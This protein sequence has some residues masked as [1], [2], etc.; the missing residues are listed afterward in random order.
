MGSGGNPIPPLSLLD[1]IEDSAL[2]TPTWCPDELATAGPEHLDRAYVA[3]YD[4][5]ASTD[6][7]AE[8]AQLRD[9]GQKETHT[10]VDL[11]AGTGGLALAAASFCRRVVGVDVSPA[12]LAILRDRAAHLGLGNLE[13]VRAGFLSYEHSGEPADVVYSRNALHHLPDFWKVVALRRVAAMLRPGGLL[14]L[15]DLVFSC[16]PD[17][18]DG[19]VASWLAGASARG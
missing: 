7:A 11:G 6:W 10:L 13:C 15:R 18:I 17:E 2:T 1:A 4:R 8:L 9:L 12:M 19:V 3:A 5:K 14:L 16:Q